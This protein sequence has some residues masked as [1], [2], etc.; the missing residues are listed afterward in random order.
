MIKV[1]IRDSEVTIGTL[2]LPADELL[3]LDIEVEIE[4]AQVDVGE[5]T[6]C[7]TVTSSFSQGY[8]D[9]EPEEPEDTRSVAQAT[10]DDVG[11]SLIFP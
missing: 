9:L 6:L 3:E 2:T 1:S 8:N 11:V 7:N 10:A 4:S 5:I